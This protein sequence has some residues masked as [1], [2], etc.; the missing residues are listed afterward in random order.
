MAVR[1]SLAQLAAVSRERRH[2]S[3]KPFFG[4][5]AGNDCERVG[6]LGV[7]PL[8]R[9]DNHPLA[10]LD[11]RFA[12]APLVEHGEFRGHSRL[13]RK[14]AQQRLAEGVDRGDLDAAR[15]V[16][17]AGEELSR[18]SQACIIGHPPG[19]LLQCLRERPRPQGCPSRQLLVQPVGHFGGGGSGEGQAQDPGGIGTVEH[20]PQQTVDQHPRLAGSG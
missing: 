19:Q 9:S 1:Q 3:A 8:P 17:N 20:Q 2:Q 5:M 13:Q 11:Q 7:V 16:E 14:A 10:S 18:P 12:G 4:S 15:C 6:E